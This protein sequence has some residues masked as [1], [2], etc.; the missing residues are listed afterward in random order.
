[1]I[2]APPSP[3]ARP[4]PDPSLAG[5][6]AAV[7]RLRATFGEA[8]EIGVV[9]GSGLG[10]FASELSERTA[11]PTSELGLPAPSVAGHRGEIVVGVREGRRVVALAGRVH[12]YEGYDAA[13]VAM[14]TRALARWGVRGLILTSAVGGLHAEWRTGT[15]VLIHDHLNFLGGNPLRGPNVD[16][17]GP[18]FPDLSNAYPVRPRALARTVAAARGLPSPLQGVYA[19][20]PGPSYETPAEIRMLQRLGADVVGMSVVPEAIAAAHAGMELLV[21]GVVANPGAGL[22]PDHLTH[23]DV[24]AAMT[25]AGASVVNL[26]SGIV[27]AW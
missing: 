23:A 5:I 8:P 4:T 6:D 26:L 11:V 3:D 7:A 20:M 16:E 10:A 25:A 21:L 2:P 9:L 19:A 24:T 12:M 15:V 17:L 13:T 22:S 14:A 18:R 1:M 27:A